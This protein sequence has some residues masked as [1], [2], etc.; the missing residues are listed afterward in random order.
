MALQLALT[1]LMP[2]SSSAGKPPPPA[3]RPN[4]LLFL[5]DDMGY[6]DL[7]CFGGSEVATPA[8]DRMAAEG[9]KLTTFYSAAPVCTP[10]RAGLLLGLLPKRTGFCGPGVMWCNSLSGIHPNETTWA[11]ALQQR[12]HYRTLMVGKWHVGHTAG[13]LPTDHGFG[14]FLGVP[15]SQDIGYT[16]GNTTAGHSCD[17]AHCGNA[18]Y[19]CYPLPLLRGERIIQQPVNL[20][21]L[22][23]RYTAE[24]LTFLANATASAG[25]AQ[26]LPWAVYYAFDHVHTPQFGRPAPGQAASPRGPFGD[27]LSQVDAAVGAVLAKVRQMSRGRR[28]DDD[29]GGGGVAAPA[30]TRTLAMLTSDNGSPGGA[31]ISGMNSPFSGTKFQTWEGVHMPSLWH[32]NQICCCCCGCCC[33]CCYSD[34]TWPGLVLVSFWSM[35]MAEMHGPVMLARLGVPGRGCAHAGDRVVAWGHPRRCHHHRPG[36]HPG[37]LRHLPRARRAVSLLLLLILSHARGLP[38]PGAA[39]AGAGGRGGAAAA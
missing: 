24:V 4:F 9:M 39:A 2:P 36:L 35:Q 18:S 19:G 33:C 23:P 20:S 31:L 21:T 13:H 16:T 22:T 26:P 32:S 17:V 25:G 37:Y 28:S 27:A 10:S 3:A 30:A 8:V 11:A 29:G 14:Q 5:V 6:G 34:A 15:Y 1:M 7:S 38:Q 12:A